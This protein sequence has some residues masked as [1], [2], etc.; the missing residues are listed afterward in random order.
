MPQ[1]SK[2]DDFTPPYLA[3][4]AY[5]SATVQ[6]FVMA[7][8]GVQTAPRANGAD[9]VMAFLALCAREAEGRPAHVEL[10]WHIDTMGYRNDVLMPYWTTREGMDAFWNRA[11]VE[12]WMQAEHV[13]GVGWWRECLTAPTTS[14]DGSYSLPN[15]RYGV[16]R[17]SRIEVQQF[18]GYMGSMR[19]RIPD[20]LDG[21]ADAPPSRISMRDDATSFGRR[22]RIKQPPA[23][24]CFIRG[25]FAWNEASPE[26][27]AIYLRDMMPVYREG[28]D[29][30]RDNPIDANCI[31][32]RM[33]DEI[34]LGYDNGI[35]SE[36]LGWFLSLA[37]LEKWTREHP[38]HLAIMQ[39]IAGYMQAHNFKPKIN[40]GHEV[41]VIPAGQCLLEYANCHPKTGFL[42]YFEA[43]EMTPGRV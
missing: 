3:Y 37:D 23:N 6:L 15:V 11:D 4:Q 39:T 19:D 16:S 41:I 31:S 42:P 14:L 17:Y 27:Q 7:M 5:P 9:R 34:H 2:P 29:Y 8:V 40:L 26:E 13:T 18:H 1:R 12:I 21:T 43:V 35:Q 28:A 24:L 32:M 36:I 30:L 10:A 33:V 38:R 22:L 25:A 20:Y